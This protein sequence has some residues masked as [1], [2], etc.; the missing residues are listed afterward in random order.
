VTQFG[1]TAVTNQAEPG[2]GSVS[3]GPRIKRN[4]V[5]IQSMHS[6]R[7]DWT[8]GRRCRNP[9]PD[10]AGSRQ[11]GA[12]ILWQGSWIA[13]RCCQDR[14]AKQL[15]RATR[16]QNLMARQLDC[17]TMLPD[18]AAN[19][20]DRGNKVPESCGKAVAL[21]DDAARS[22]RKSVGSRHDAAEILSQ[23]KLN[24]GEGAEILS[25]IKLDCSADQPGSPP[26]SVGLARR[27]GWIRCLSQ[28]RSFAS[29]A[30][31]LPG[32]GAGPRMAPWRCEGR[33]PHRR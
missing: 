13:G 19:Q 12:R 27:S 29:L 22:G 1:L 20:L 33:P 5:P 18:R 7:V 15:D 26:G 14:A 28:Y 31:P 8:A 23:I 16:C 9:A 11:Q 3:L 25:P 4:S 6:P 2:H 32:P 24:R 30:F 21:R 17:G 10:Q